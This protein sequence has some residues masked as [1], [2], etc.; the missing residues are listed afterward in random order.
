MSI[1]SPDEGGSLLE[2]CPCLL[3]FISAVV[4]NTAS[5]P[6][7]LSF[8]LKLAGLAAATEKGFRMLQVELM[9]P[10]TVTALFIDE[11]WLWW[12]L[13]FL[14]ESSL[15]D[16]V[17]NL[18]RWQEAGFWEDPCLRI[19]WIQGLNNLLLHPKALNF[20]VQSGDTSRWKLQHLSWC[21]VCY[22]KEFD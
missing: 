22:K 5:D 16:L 4:S 6:G 1:F 13:Y 17:F 3:D 10:F 11:V 18:Q 8:T 20:F 15:L 14:Q 12:W 7:V 9:T 21:F 2:A 19:G